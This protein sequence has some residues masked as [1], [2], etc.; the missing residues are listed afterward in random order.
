MHFRRRHN[1]E[2]GARSRSSDWRYRQVT[3][4]DERRGT[5]N[6]RRRSTAFEAD[7]AE[8]MKDPAFAE[9]YNDRYGRISAAIQSNDREALRAIFYEGVEE[10]VDEDMRRLDEVWSNNTKPA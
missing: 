4:G 9:A 7:L 6:E 5:P 10:Q 3:K 2:H 8:W 1:R